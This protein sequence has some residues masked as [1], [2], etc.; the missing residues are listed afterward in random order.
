VL[1]F[2]FAQ[3]LQLAEQQRLPD[4]LIRAGIRRLLGSRLRER[5]RGTCEDHQ[6]YLQDFLAAA[7]AA[8]IALVPEKANEQH[9][10]VPAEFFEI[11][12]GSRRKYSSCY[13]PA[14]I[15]NLDQA[16]TAALKRTCE[17]AELNDGMSILEL[18]CGWG[19]LSLWMAEH[20]PQSQIHAVSNSHSQ[21]AYIME[22]AAQRQLK[23]IHVI[24]ADMNDFQP[25]QTYDR[26]VSIEMFEH[27]RNHE[28]LLSRIASWLNPAGKLY[29]HIFCHRA[30]P[31]LFTSSGP[32]DWMAE[33]FFSGGMM[34]SD[35]LLLHY[36]KDLI[37]ERRWRWSGMHYHHTCE[38]WLEKCDAAREQVLEIMAKT[39]GRDQA[40][41]WLQRWRMFF[42]ACSELFRFGQGDEWWVSHYLF[43]KSR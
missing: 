34:P 25:P 26:V 1:T 17:M 37:L 35:E 15:S 5:N 19:S 41:L 12:L 42:M 11:V 23:N 7:R 10:E 9:Y 20:Y 4:V 24:T 2:L 13:W 40:K 3:T 6:R 29:V 28:L 43:E 32:Q 27:M 30:Q 18:G 33:F 16:E 22:Q 38:A 36:Q 21:R 8:P 14:Q 31:Y 39:Y